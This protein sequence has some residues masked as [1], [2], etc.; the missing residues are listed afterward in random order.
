MLPLEVQLV[1]HADEIAYDTHD[2]D[3]GL[4]SGALAEEQVRTVPL[5]RETE[6]QVL[7]EHEDFKHDQRLRW[8]AVVRRLIATLIGDALAE[9]RR[10]LLAQ[11]IARLEDVR[12][13]AH[14][15]VGFSTELAPRKEELEAFL[16]AHFYDG[17][18]V[19]TLTALWE[20]RLKQ[21]FA[22][23][24]DDPHHLPEDYQRRVA[25]D[26][27]PPE[28]VICDYVAGMTDRYASRQWELLVQK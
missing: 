6:A 2:L 24:R 8:R 20:G 3:D 16:T 18:K 22:A 11:G 10:R 25:P 28:R 7:R 21:L 5:W 14:E 4:V 23:Y 13:C 9:T 26:G 12:H 27:E 19:R 15:L 17:P 1:G